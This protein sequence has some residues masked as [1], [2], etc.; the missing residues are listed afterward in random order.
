MKFTLYL[1]SIV[2]LL[3]GA[4]NSGI[5]GLTGTNVISVI[6][7]GIFG[8]D[9]L[10]SF[11]YTIIGIC[12][13]YLASKPQTYMPFIGETIVPAYV[14]PD[15]NNKNRAVYIDGIKYKFD[16]LVHIKVPYADA[17]SIIYWASKPFKTEYS[18]AYGDFAN[19][20]IANVINKRASLY[21][22][23]PE[24]LHANRLGI[25]PHT[26]SKYVNYRIVYK[27][28]L[29]SEIM[30]HDINCASAIPQPP[31]PP[32]DATIK[33]DSEEQEIRCTFED[34]KIKCNN[35]EVTEILKNVSCDG[36]I[37]EAA[38]LLGVVRL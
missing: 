10:S 11:F 23:C 7:N 26:F 18:T 37:A 20:G 19:S 38:R 17:I 35:P 32:P 14:L 29:L 2:L 12:A 34:G 21:I 31:P 13:V 25:I 15:S 4:I 6:S 3:A 30:T 28:G 22:I 36:K 8:V 9:I 24:K 1:I 27:N 16:T 33:C 5:C